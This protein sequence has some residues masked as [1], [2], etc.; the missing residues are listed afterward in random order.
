MKYTGKDYDFEKLRFNF[1]ADI[2]GVQI[3]IYE[4]D[5]IGTEYRFVKYYGKPHSR[6][7]TKIR[8]NILKDFEKIL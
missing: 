4:G 3:T 5:E 8:L 7:P 6:R 1:L 2:E